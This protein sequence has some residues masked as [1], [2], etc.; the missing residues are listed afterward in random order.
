MNQDG[1]LFG[2]GSGI[3]GQDDVTS[4]MLGWGTTGHSTDLEKLMHGDINLDGRT[5]LS[6]WQ[7][8]VEALEESSG[9]GLQS[10]GTACGPTHRS[11]RTAD[12]YSLFDCGDIALYSCD[13]PWWQVPFQQ[14]SLTLKEGRDS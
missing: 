7:L 1:I 13:H 6:D 4:F 9:Q 11:S 3:P 2:N 12:G 5:S 8:L 14:G 10:S